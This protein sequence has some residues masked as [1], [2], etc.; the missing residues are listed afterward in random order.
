MA[1]GNYTTKNELQLIAKRL[2]I[3]SSIVKLND[4]SNDQLTSTLKTIHANHVQLTELISSETS[5]SEGKI[6]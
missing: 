2:L 6:V 3:L 4:L 5:M 1:N